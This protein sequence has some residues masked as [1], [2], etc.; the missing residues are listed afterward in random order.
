MALTLIPTFTPSGYLTLN[1]P[2]VPPPDPTG[3][4]TPYVA[5]ANTLALPAGS[6]P[7]TVLIQNIG[8]DPVY[9]LLTAAAASTT[10]TAPS[11]SKT[12][13]VASATGIAVNQAVI[14]V[15]LAEGT[16]VQAISGTTVTLNRPTVAALSTT[17]LSFVVQV[18]PQTGIAVH[19][20]API[21]LAYVASGFI[22]VINTSGSS[23]ATVNVAVGV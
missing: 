14:G 23:N 8:P 3:M 21:A 15:G 17:A 12:V 19:I 20:Y 16:V 6:S 7:A 11:G 10:G 5:K 13:T 9:V 2:P 22:S 18:T 4:N 1:T